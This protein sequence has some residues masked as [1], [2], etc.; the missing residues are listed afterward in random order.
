MHLSLHHSKF[1]VH[2]F[3]ILKLFLQ[4]HLLICAA[5]ELEIKPF[6]ASIKEKD[7]GKIRVLITGVGLLS[8]T[9]SITKEVIRSKPDL[10]IQAGIAGIIDEQLQAGTVVLIRNE[11]VGDLGAMENNRFHSLADLQLVH[12]DSTPWQKGKLGNQEDF[13]FQ[14][15][16]P[17][18][19]GVTVNEIST[20]K[21]RISYY[22]SLGA[23]VESM[24]GAALHFTCLK[25]GIPFLQIRALSNLAGE[26]D[27][28]QWK[29]KESIEKL[30]AALLE[31]IKKTTGK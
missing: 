4:M 24:E 19:D 6:M 10:I 23:Q 13:L 3:D 2:R 8:S 31:I 29:M 14:F 20:S 18:A 21:E 27:K 11:F 26:R 30:N 28:S 7:R 9:Y 17:L 25:E 15:G 1:L 22:K 16:F 12:P 5:T